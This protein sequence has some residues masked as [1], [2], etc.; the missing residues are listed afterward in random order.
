ML[1]TRN[2]QILDLSYRVVKGRLLGGVSVSHTMP[3]LDG[4]L[5]LGDWQTN[6][7]DLYQDS[8]SR[9]D[10]TKLACCRTFLKEQ[11]RIQAMTEI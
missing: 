1:L 7:I 10:L 11:F 2:H 6:T 4:T 3:C 5:N 8:C 9:I